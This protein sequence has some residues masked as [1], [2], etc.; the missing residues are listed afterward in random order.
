M[1][2]HF[3]LSLRSNKRKI[4]KAAKPDWTSLNKPDIQNIFMN[5]VRNKFDLQAKQPTYQPISYMNISKHH[6]EKLQ[7]K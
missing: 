1:T 5:E 6:A 4:H 7:K 3:K 2:A